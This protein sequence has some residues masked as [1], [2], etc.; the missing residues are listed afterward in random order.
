MSCDENAAKTKSVEE[1]TRKNLDLMNA[2]RRELQEGM[3]TV[4]ANA[5]RRLICPSI[6]DSK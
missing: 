4:K 5:N 6:P 1:T 2:T 3:K